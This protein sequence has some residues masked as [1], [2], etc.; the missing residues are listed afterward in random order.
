MYIMSCIY[1]VQGFLFELAAGQ[2]A[3]YDKTKCW[4]LNF[5]NL[6]ICLL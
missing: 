3:A 6:N 5:I 2:I 1:N 4:Q